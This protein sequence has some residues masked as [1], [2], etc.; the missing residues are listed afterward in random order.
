MKPHITELIDEL[1][2]A[3][4]DV[5]VEQGPDPDYRRFAE[6]RLKDVRTRLEEAIEVYIYQE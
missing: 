3:A 1:I 5:Q 4:R 6:D 2:S